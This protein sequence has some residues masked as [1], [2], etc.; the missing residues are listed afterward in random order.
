MKVAAARHEGG[1]PCGQLRWRASAAPAN[2]RICHCRNCQKATG[3][4][5]FARAV[6]LA[7][8]FDW[9]GEVLAWAS[10]PRIDRLACARCGAPVLSAPKD[11]PARVGVTLAS[12]DE[13]DAVRPQMH[14]WVSEKRS[15]V[16]IDDGL[17]QYPEG[18]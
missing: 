10:S 18:P 7:E 16:R 6:F 1:C 14:I 12:F 5:F 4:P 15:W 2:V 13:P 17:P 11:L 9:S 8:D 3:G